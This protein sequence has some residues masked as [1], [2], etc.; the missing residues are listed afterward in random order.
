MSEIKIALV[1]GGGIGKS[2]ITI[3]HVEGKFQDTFYD[4]TIEDSYVKEGK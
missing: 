4:P 3:R 1:G 2:C